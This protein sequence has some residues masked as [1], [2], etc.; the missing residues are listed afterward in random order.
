MVALEDT[1]L[2]ALSPP[3]CCCCWERQSIF[4]DRVG[5]TKLPAET[6]AIL[7]CSKTGTLPSLPMV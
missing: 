1:M 7:V 6:A 2:D 4:R 5:K 3:Q